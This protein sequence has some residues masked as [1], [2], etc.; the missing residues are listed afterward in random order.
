MDETRQPAMENPARPQPLKRLDS[1]ENPFLPGGNLS[2]ETD[3]LLK[4]ATIIRD[5]FL[6][7]DEAR[8]RAE[9]T[10]AKVDDTPVQEEHTTPVHTSPVAKPKENG[11]SGEPA[12]PGSVHVDVNKDTQASPGSPQTRNAVQKDKKKGNKCCTVM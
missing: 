5:Q 7:D 8:L 4:R 9:Q 6:L 11:Q 2:K 12:S 1:K 3:D 10:A